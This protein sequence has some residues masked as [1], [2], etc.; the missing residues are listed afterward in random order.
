MS[1][2]CTAAPTNNTAHCLTLLLFNRS[3]FTEL[4]HIVAVE[5]LQKETSRTTAASF[6][7]PNSVKLTK[8]SLHPA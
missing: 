5:F 7:N 6:N 2:V 4:I 3:S 8:Y 1:P